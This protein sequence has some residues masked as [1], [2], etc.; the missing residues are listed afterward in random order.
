MIFSEV[1]EA[2]NELLDTNE[3]PDAIFTGADKLTTNTFR[4]L[5][6]RN[7][8]LPE[9]I[10]LIGFCN[11][12]LTELLDPALSVV[13]QPAFEMGEVSTGLLMQLI[14]SKRPVNEYNTKVLSTELILRNS[15]A[16]KNPVGKPIAG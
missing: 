13:K 5:K 4:V 3:R 9:E 11:S 1:E 16:Y 6:S 2:L 7:F 12:E 8:K 10:G 15:T 14:E